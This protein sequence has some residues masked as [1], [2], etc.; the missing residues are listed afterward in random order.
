MTY[1]LAKKTAE[2]ISSNASEN[3]SENFGLLYY[4]LE[5]IQIKDKNSKDKTFESL[6]NLVA[7]SKTIYHHQQ[8]I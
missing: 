3:A 1:P 5:K 2:I 6:Q 8:L 7:K 4:R